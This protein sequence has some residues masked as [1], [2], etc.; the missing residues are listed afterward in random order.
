MHFAGEI[1]RAHVDTHKDTFYT[2]T[3]VGEYLRDL[4]ER[5]ATQGEDVDLER[6]KGRG[7]GNVELKK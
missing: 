5:E 4:R 1:G 6:T 2:D 7:G 3:H